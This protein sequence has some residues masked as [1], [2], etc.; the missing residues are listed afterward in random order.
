MLGWN[1]GV[2]QHVVNGPR[3]NPNDGD[4]I[5]F[6]DRP[7]GSQFEFRLWR[8]RIS[9]ISMEQV[10]AGSNLVNTH[11]SADWGSNDW[12]LLNLRSAG[13]AE[14]IFTVKSNGDSLTQLTFTSMNFSPLWSPSCSAYGYQR[15]A[16]PG[17]TVRVDVATGYHDTVPGFFD[18]STC[19]YSDSHAATV[20][21][22]GV[23]H[24][25]MTTDQTD[26]VCGLPADLYDFSTPSGL[27]VLPGHHTAVWTHAG[28]LFSTDMGTGA[29]TQMLRTCNSRYFVGLDYSPQTNKLVTTRITRTPL[30]DHDLLIDTD[31][32][33][34]NP[35]GTGQQ[36]LEIPFPE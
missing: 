13:G 18:Q 27:A 19:W 31:I 30:N 14:N 17:G 7:Y 32:V 26:Q 36:V 12:I 3:F 21:P 15:S 25:D 9:S 29:T 11:F 34:M 5:I 4:E 22:Y 1:F 23:F 20:T 28:G 35:D 10:L 24:W 16:A 6:M 33:L 8:Y 2:P